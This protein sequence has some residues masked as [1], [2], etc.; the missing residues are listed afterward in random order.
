MFAKFGTQ[1]SCGAFRSDALHRVT[2]ADLGFALAGVFFRGPDSSDRIGIFGTV[3]RPRRQLLDVVQT[4]VG[5]LIRMRRS[6]GQRIWRADA[7]MVN[8]TGAQAA[9]WRTIEALFGAMAGQGSNPGPTPNGAT[10]C[11]QTPKMPDLGSAPTRR[12]RAGDNA[13]TRGW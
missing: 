9:L 12:R 10:V 2:E 11:R 4:L 3:S 1:A 13:G 7:L 8:L 5:R 6:Q